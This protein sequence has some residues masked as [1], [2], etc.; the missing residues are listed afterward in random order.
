MNKIA[1]IAGLGDLPQR[2]I[3]QLELESKEFV[4][5]SISASTFRSSATLYQLNVTEIDQLIELMLKENCKNMLFI[6]KITKPKFSEL[7]LSGKAMKLMTMIAK[8][9]FFAD[10]AILKSVHQFFSDEGFNVI[11]VQDI[12]KDLFIEKGSATIAPPNKAQLQDIKLGI[13]LCLKIGELDIGQAILIQNSIILGIEAAEGTDE[14]IQRCK[15]LRQGKGGIL[16][17]LKK[18][19]QDDKMDLP[20]FGLQT[21][22]LL[23]ELGYDGAVVSSGSTI[24]TPK[25]EVI[26]LLNAKGLFLYG[27]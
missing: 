24:I 5:F 26:N 12:L 8:N 16:V 3:T 10:D 20:T 21:A 6:G 13:D 9:Q 1:L 23:T 7:K 14:L 22:N 11:S 27:V 18:P 25:N 15:N 2:V 19:Q 4:I 17:K